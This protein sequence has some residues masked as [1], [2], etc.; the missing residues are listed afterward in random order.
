MKIREYRRRF[1]AGGRE[2][3]ALVELY[4]RTAPIADL[5]QDARGEGLVTFVHDLPNHFTLGGRLLPATEASDGGIA[6]ARARELWKIFG[7]DYV[8]ATTLVVE[9]LGRPAKSS[10][11][12][13]L[14]ERDFQRSEVLKFLMSPRFEGV[15]TLNYSMLHWLTFSVKD[16]APLREVI[17]AFVSFGSDVFGAYSN[18][19]ESKIWLRSY[20]E[21]HE[22]S[23]GYIAMESSH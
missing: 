11:A 6:P 15:L 22:V 21:F 3:E 13:Y 4:P 17:D 16:G 2:L 10:N 5:M 8:A 19:N 1:T 12:V 14:G 18:K 7:G 20:R 23:L 9:S